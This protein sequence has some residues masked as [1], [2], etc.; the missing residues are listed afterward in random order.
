MSHCSVLGAVDF[1]AADGR[2][3]QLTSRA[4]RR[5]VAVLALHAITMV[6]GVV[7]KEL[8]LLS[9]GALRTSI[10]PLRRLI[11]AE[12]LATGSIGY[13]F[14]ASIDAADFERQVGDAFARDDASARTALETALALCRGLPY[15]EFA[16]EP[17]A[18][19]EVLRLSELW[20]A[21][22]EELAVLT[23]ASGEHVAAFAGLEPLI[24][25]EPYRDRPRALL[26]RALAEAGRSTDAL[27][28]FQAYRAVLVADIG[29][30]PSSDL[31]ELDN[32]I[33]ESSDLDR[34]R[35]AG[36]MAWGRERCQSL[37]STGCHSR[38]SSQRLGSGLPRCTRLR[39]A[40][41]RVNDD[42]ATLVDSMV[43]APLPHT[44]VHL[45]R[46]QIAV[47]R[48]RFDAME[49]MA[50]ELEAAGDADRATQMRNTAGGM[51]SAI[52]SRW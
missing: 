42:T 48:R 2:P 14:R 45:A 8:L 3:L 49:L 6:S 50:V 18:I 46:T 41:P 43:E 20:A 24:A 22:V 29:I 30:E 35:R 51:T 39:A 12:C 25:K 10:S 17:W 47:H 52:G 32:A 31:V 11:G 7:L 23:L 40:S 21:P 19:G 37:R 16:H 28:A 5:L 36:N 27:R 1:R 4:Q 38:S 13:E 44:S 26:I 33:V 9:P 34:S 15:R